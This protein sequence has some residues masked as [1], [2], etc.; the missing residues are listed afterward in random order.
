MHDIS[1]LI[2]RKINASSCQFWSGVI[3]VINTKTRDQSISDI[4]VAVRSLLNNKELHNYIG[5]IRVSIY[6]SNSFNLTTNSVLLN[7]NSKALTT[8]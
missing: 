6:N 1:F 3:S 2:R 5:N 8:Y 4:D 7:N